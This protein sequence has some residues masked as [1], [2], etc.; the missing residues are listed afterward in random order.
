MHYLVSATHS[1]FTLYTFSLVYYAPISLVFFPS[2]SNPSSSPLHLLFP[3]FYPIATASH[4]PPHG[5]CGTCLYLA[6]HLS[7][8][9]PCQ[10]LRKRFSDH[11]IWCCLPQHHVTWPCF[12]S[13][14]AFMSLWAHVFI[15]LFI[16]YTRIQW[17]QGI[18]FVFLP[19][20]SQCLEQDNSV[21]VPRQNPTPSF[22]FAFKGWYLQLFSPDIAIRLT[23]IQ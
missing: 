17:I 20:Y 14:I 23:I 19:L 1:D 21:N 5:L 3:P 22:W 15:C 13:F 10:L 2:S 18:H 7:S 11:R 12:L 4:P 6:C 9:T 16:S 8:S